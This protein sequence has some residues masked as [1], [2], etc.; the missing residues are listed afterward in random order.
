LFDPIGCFKLL[1]PN[2]LHTLNNR[3]FRIRAVDSAGRD[4]AVGA[5][6]NAPR[7][8]GSGRMSTTAGTLDDLPMS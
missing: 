5:T 3:Y 4:V 1:S 6:A 8:A 2:I 7:F